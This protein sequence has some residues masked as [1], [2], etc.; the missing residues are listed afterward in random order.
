MKK[1]MSSERG[2][3]GVVVLG[4]IVALFLV[5]GFLFVE[6]VPEGKVAVVYS[7]SGGATEVL[8]PGWNLI[9]LFE[10]TQEYPTRIEIVKTSVNVTTNDGKKLKLPVRYEYKVD[11]KQVLNIFKEL[12]SQDIEQIQDGYLS[13]KLFKASRDVISQYSVLDIFGT[14]NAEASVKITEKMAETS[15]DLGFVIN[16]ATLGN[17]EVDKET[18]KAIDERVKAAQQLE[19]LKL[20]KQIAQETAEKNKIEADGAAQVKITEAKGQAEANKLLEQSITPELLKKMELEAR[21][22]HGWVEIIGAEG[23]IVDADKKN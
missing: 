4:A 22:K 2:N 18:Q 11:K 3:I 17:P 9:G 5:V 23:M 1:F 15:K 16:D 10:K 20:D 19:K 6:R 21:M 7:P 12:G 8:D 13:Q 14:K